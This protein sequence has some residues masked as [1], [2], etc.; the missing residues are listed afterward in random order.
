MLLACAELKRLID[1]KKSAGKELVMEESIYDGKLTR[2]LHKDEKL[3]EVIVGWNDYF[4][5]KTRKTNCLM[6]SAL[7]TNF[8]YQTYLDEDNFNRKSPLFIELMM[9][10]KNNKKFKKYQ[11]VLHNTFIKCTRDKNVIFF[12]N[13]LH[14]W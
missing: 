9:S 4:D 14:F 3:F 1:D 2:L 10:L 8:R 13:F 12:W 7:D 5:V 11:F 6:I